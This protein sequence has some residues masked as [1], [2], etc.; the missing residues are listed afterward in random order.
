MAKIRRHKYEKT[1]T[2]DVHQY[3]EAKLSA[4]NHRL[5]YG[6]LITDTDEKTYFLATKGLKVSQS[7]QIK[8]MD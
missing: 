6:F 4:A 2:T 1:L 8:M 7:L 5:N 3:W